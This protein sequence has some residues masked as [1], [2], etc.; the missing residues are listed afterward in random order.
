MRNYMSE[1]SIQI[2]Y[3]KIEIKLGENR[4]ITPIKKGFEK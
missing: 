3:Q 2:R 1:F 4:I